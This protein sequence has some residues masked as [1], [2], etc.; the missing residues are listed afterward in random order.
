MKPLM[1]LALAAAAVAGAQ[2]PLAGSAAAGSRGYVVAYPASC[3]CHPRFG[4]YKTTQYWPLPRR[5]VSKYF[6]L[7]SYPAVRPRMR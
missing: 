5:A 4:Y 3:C 6:R 2:I 7:V 1:T